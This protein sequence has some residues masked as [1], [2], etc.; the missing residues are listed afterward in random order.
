MISNLGPGQTCCVWLGSRYLTKLR[1]FLE[2]EN[3]ATGAESDGLRSED[4]RD[5][6][7]TAVHS[8]PGGFYSR[9]VRDRETGPFKGAGPVRDWRKGTCA[10]S[11]ARKMRKEGG[12]S[13]RT[14][15][16]PPNGRWVG[17]NQRT[18][19][20]QLTDY[21][22]TCSVTAVGHLHNRSAIS[23]K[24]IVLTGPSF[25]EREERETAGGDGA[26]AMLR[27]SVLDAAMTVRP[28]QQ[29]AAIDPHPSRVTEWHTWPFSMKNPQFVSLLTTFSK[30]H[31]LFPN[32]IRNNEIR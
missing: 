11:A 29:N 8:S 22:F 14:N 12:A 30:F 20:R 24:M 27:M 7:S 31:Q 2:T 21:R 1:N 32:C 10:P 25:H 26:S 5:R 3:A 6:N 16:V 23:T 9:H 17:T 19:A 18:G 28:L 15:R 4:F 13:H